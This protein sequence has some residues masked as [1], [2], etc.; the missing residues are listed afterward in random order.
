MAQYCAMLFHFRTMKKILFYVLAIA[1]IVLAIRIGIIL[2]RDFDRLT[3]YGFG[4][5]TGIVILFLICLAASFWLG[6]KVYKE[7]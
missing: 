7:L 4:Y 2:I 5:L 1:T 6:R 3:N